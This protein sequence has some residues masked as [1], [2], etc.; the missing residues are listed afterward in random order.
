MFTREVWHTWAFEQVFQTTL[1]MSFSRD[2]QWGCAP[3]NPDTCAL[4]A[5][6]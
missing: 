3:C 6:L 4:L 1:L 5:G 2:M